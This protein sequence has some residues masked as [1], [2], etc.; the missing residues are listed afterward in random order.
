MKY[1]R[2]LLSL[3]FV[4]S[5]WCALSNAQTSSTVAST[6]VP[7]LVNYSGRVLDAQSKPISGIAGIT[8][9]IYKDQYEG[10]PLWMETQNVQA[11][12]RGNYTVQ[13][14]ATSSTGL[15]MDLFISG[16]ARWLGVRVNG[17]HRRQRKA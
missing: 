4:L 9:S 2:D 10:A 12:A 14:G 8:F 6:V 1:F 13:L 5:F 11:D 17:G 16:E 7:S 3:L 15:P